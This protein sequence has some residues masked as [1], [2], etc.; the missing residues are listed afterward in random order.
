M[1]ETDPFWWITPV[2]E[3]EDEALRSPSPPDESDG[4]VKEVMP[5]DK[6]KLE[7]PTNVSSQFWFG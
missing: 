6:E 1:A 3:P 7:A 5:R 4:A 2:P